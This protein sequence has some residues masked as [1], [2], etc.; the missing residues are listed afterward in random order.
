MNPLEIST[1]QFRRLAERVTNLASEYLDHQKIAPAT[2]GEETLRFRGIGGLSYEELNPFNLAVLKRVVERGRVYLSNA[3]LRGK[4]SLRACIVNHRTKDADIDGVVPEVLAAA[5]EV[6]RSPF[7]RRR[8][9][10]FRTDA[11]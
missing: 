5:K 4:F 3:S 10:L 6:G 2:D 9:L 1:D 7:A 11:I 8:V